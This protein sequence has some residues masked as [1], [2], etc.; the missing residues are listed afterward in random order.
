MKLSSPIIARLIDLKQ[1]ESE[2]QA[3]FEIAADKTSKVKVLGDV[4]IGCDG[5][6]STVRRKLNPKNDPLVYSGITM[7]RV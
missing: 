2:V 1:T 4:L 5:I 6:H 7:W 3:I